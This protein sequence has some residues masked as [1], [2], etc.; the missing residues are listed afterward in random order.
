MPCGSLPPLLSACT[1]P[2]CV[3]TPPPPLPFACAHPLHVHAMGRGAH[4]HTNR[5]CSPPCMPPP[6][7]PSPL[8]A[9]WV[10]P[11]CHVW[12]GF[13]PPPASVHNR[14]M[15]GSARQVRPPP[16]PLV[17]APTHAHWTAS[18]GPHSPPP[19]SPAPVYAPTGAPCPMGTRTRGPTLHS[20]FP[21]LHP[22]HVCTSGAQGGRGARKWGGE[23]CGEVHGVHMWTGGGVCTRRGGGTRK[24]GGEGVATHPPSHS[25]V[26]PLPIHVCTPPS[27]LRAPPHV[28]PLT[29]TG[30]ANEAAC[31][32][33][34]MAAHP[35]RTYL[36]PT[37]G[38]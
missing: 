27:H 33:Q 36:R 29:R 32:G 25:H 19:F 11:N 1:P 3:C 26:C 31:K 15:L 24:R 6:R 23:V 20:P 9:L 14:G 4:V 7:A 8:H 37:P 30:H 17:T 21:P 35:P 5:G 34:A 2:H 10:P 12:Q 22:P 13:P 18:A 38:A 28:P 16:F